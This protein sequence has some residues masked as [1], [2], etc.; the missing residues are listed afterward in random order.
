MGLALLEFLFFFPS[1]ERERGHLFLFFTLDT[2][3]VFWC[4]A[5][6]SRRLKGCLYKEII[7]KGLLQLGS[8][9]TPKKVTFSIP[10]LFPCPLGVSRFRRQPL[11][12]PSP[13]LPVPLQSRILLPTPISSP[14]ILPIP[15]PLRPPP[16][17]LRTYLPPG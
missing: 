9:I 8:M 4:F 2:L 6:Y 17:C 12:L 16:L 15:L 14:S 13:S 7:S 11:A 5:S 1:P 3:I 10:F